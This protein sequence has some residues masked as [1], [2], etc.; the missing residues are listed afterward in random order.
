MHLNRSLSKIQHS[1]ESWR[2]YGINDHRLYLKLNG[3]LKALFS[4][5]EW[6]ITRHD[7]GMTE[8]EVICPSMVVYKRL[9]QK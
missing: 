1:L 7:N 5:C 6:R 3:S 8:L 2:R 9:L 4:H